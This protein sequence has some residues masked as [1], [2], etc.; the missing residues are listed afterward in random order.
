MAQNTIEPHTEN[1]LS[2]LITGIFDDTQGLIKQHIALAKVEFRSE[3]ENLKTMATGMAIGG[4][5]AAV[6]GLLVLIGIVHLVQIATGMHLWASYLTVG[7]VV[8]I[9][10]VIVMVSTKK[11]I[12]K[13]DLIPDRTIEKLTNG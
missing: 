11:D 4:A 12:A 2:G 10:G 7:L 1:N 8:A 3:L 13:S 6:G 9:G 5:L